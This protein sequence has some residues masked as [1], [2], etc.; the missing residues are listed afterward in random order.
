MAKIQIIVGTVNGTAWKAVQSAAIILQKLGHQAQ[1]N[2]ETTAQDL[3]RD[4]EEILL[5]CSHKVRYSMKTTQ[6][7][8]I[9]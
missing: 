1:V 2:E 9:L 3:I 4:E 5:V 6:H 8:K 7:F